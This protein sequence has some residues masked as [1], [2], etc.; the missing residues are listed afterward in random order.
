MLLIT[1]ISYFELLNYK[2]NIF[3]C[4]NLNSSNSFINKIIV[5]LDAH[6]DGL[7]KNN[8][9]QYII[10]KDLDSKLIEYAM[11]QSEE[12]KLIWSNPNYVFTEYHL[13][14][15]SINSD[16]YEEKDK[17]T[18]FERGKDNFLDKLRNKEVL[19]EKKSKLV[20]LLES[21]EDIPKITK[22]NKTTINNKINRKLDVIII[23][24]NYNDYLIVTLKHNTKIFENI[25]IVTS[26]DD[27]MCQK[28]CEEYKVNCV[29]TNSMFENGDKFN[30]GKALNVGINSLES[31]GF[32][33]TLDADIIVSDEIDT[34]ILNE[35]VLYTSDR[36][37]CQSYDKLLQSQQ[38]KTNIGLYTKFEEDKGL[39]FFHLFHYTKQQS[40]PEYSKNAAFDDLLFR[41]KFTEREKI[42]N[43]IIHLGKAYKN[44]DGRITERFITDIEFQSLFDDIEEYV[45]ILY[46]PTIN[47]HLLFQRPQQLMKNFANQK[48]V[49]SIFWNSRGEVRQKERIQKLNNNLFIVDQYLKIEE[50]QHLFKGKK[51][52][53][54]SHPSHH[55]IKELTD[56]DLV[57]FD[58][59][60]NPV[61]EFAEWSIELKT[62]VEKA[63]VIIASAKIMYDEHKKS[64]KPVFMLPNGSDFELFE[65]SINK[66]EKP[67]DFPDLTGPVVGYY[68]AM[69]TWLDWDI[70]EKISTKYQILMIGGNKYYNEK[71]SN[72]NIH[73]LDHKKIEELP[74][75]LSHIDV[76]IIPFKLTEMIKGCDP[77][78]FYEYISS[79][80]PPVVTQMIELERFK[81]ICYFMN[82]DNCLDIIEE[83]AN[84]DN[85]ELV[86]KRIEIAKL[87]SW[88]VRAETAVKI[89]RKYLNAK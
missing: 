64:G 27:F 40:Y 80:K 59:I 51:V 35:N 73:Y 65:K 87:N 2:K 84:E 57:I 67:N 14:N 63:D 53:W 10:K 20:N 49:R 69:A 74:N 3:N 68:G 45:T 79:G 32:I 28:I 30:K 55:Y 62:A 71:I 56:W 38:D 6:F 33:L 17:Y 29:V 76:P 34:S 39:G 82:I 43:Q 21:N 12:K 15:A 54:F 19:L 85:K 9:I 86:K 25:T 46:P 1:K 47:W 16:L 83:A 22:S 48:N 41:D 8:K 31:P 11:K 78:K 50:F 24:V 13:K 42:E 26:P 23:S 81:D 70:V 77:I 58:A 61:D 44:W 4:L 66:L 88:N 7:P 5:F 18:L 75:Y 37:I 36:W 89:I 72:D 60:D 52:Y